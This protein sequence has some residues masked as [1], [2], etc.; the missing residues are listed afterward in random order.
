MANLNINSL[1]KSIDQLRI[2]MQNSSIDILAINETK[3]DHSVSDDEISIPG[4]YHIRK[5]RNRYGGGV[6]LY[7]RESLPFSERN[8]L[9]ISDSLEMLCIEITKPHNK[10]FL[11]VTWYRPPNSEVSLFNEYETFLR[12][13][14]L[15]NIEVIIMGDLNCDIIKCPPEA[16]TRRL[17]FLSSLYQYRQLINEPTRVTRTSATLIDLILTNKEE[18]ISKSGVIHLGIS[19]HSLVFAVRKYCVTKSRQKTRYVRNFKRFNAIN[20]LNDLSQ[21]PWENVALYDN[22]NVCWRV[23]R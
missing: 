23:W 14:D 19:D 4:Y 7:V 6:L 16:H 5:D 21:M 12:K 2:I 3:I 15:E 18:N 20:F 17:Q 11:I 10:S 13:C 8:D 1:L 9:L 22:P